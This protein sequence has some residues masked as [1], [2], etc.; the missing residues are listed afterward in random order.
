[1]GSER[2]RFAATVG[3]IAVLVAACLNSAPTPSPTQVAVDPTPSPSAAPP[4]SPPP[5]GPAR[6]APP[7]VRRADHLS[8][9]PDAR[10]QSPPHVVPAGRRHG[11]D[12][13]EVG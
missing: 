7:P 9:E 2:I 13:P 6:P 1:M 3:T 5:H 4:T 12:E 11:T 10:G 8:P